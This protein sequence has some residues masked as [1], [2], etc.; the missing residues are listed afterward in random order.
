MSIDQCIL[1]SYCYLFTNVRR[2]VKLYAYCFLLFRN[3]YIVVFVLDEG[4]DT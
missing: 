3:S 4:E 1:C 2:T